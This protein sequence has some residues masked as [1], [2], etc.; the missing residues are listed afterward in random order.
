MDGVTFCL[1]HGKWHDASCWDPLAAE[2]VRRGHRCVAP[3]LPFE[4]PRTTHE[5]RA[6][7][8]LDAL[9]DVGGPV[10][11]VGHSLSAA[12]APLVAVAVEA[13]L[14]YLCPAPTGPF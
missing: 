7:P 11:V 8:A 13:T 2:L 1:L 12:I 3:E 10:A 4:D 9:R 6:R 14:V 5:Q